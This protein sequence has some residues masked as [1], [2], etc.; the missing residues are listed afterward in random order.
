MKKYSIKKILIFNLI[1]NILE[2]IWVPKISNYVIIYLFK[3]LVA[4]IVFKYLG[5]FSKLEIS[6]FSNF[7]NKIIIGENT[8]ISDSNG[9][10]VSILEDVKI[11]RNVTISAD[12]G[13]KIHIGKG[14]LIGP[15]T[16]I[17]SSNHFIKKNKFI[18]NKYKSG[19]I[20]IGENCWIGANCVILPGTKLSDNCTVGALSVTNKNYGNASLVCGKIA[21]TKK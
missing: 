15:N 11:A 16:V 20:Y 4:D 5:R 3:I 13:G 8:S 10:F 14:T 2:I 17:R 12:F 7:G 6:D 9:G 1:R 18:D 21:E 19:D